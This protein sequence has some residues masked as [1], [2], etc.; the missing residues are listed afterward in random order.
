MFSICNNLAQ[1]CLNVI[2]RFY[3]VQAIVIKDLVSGVRLLGFK[4]QLVPLQLRLL[5]FKLLVSELLDLLE[6][7]SG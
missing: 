6:A 5:S 2:C 7:L 1:S 4:T 3:Q